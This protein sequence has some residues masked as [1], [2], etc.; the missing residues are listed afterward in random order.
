MELWKTGKWIWAEGYDSPNTYI[1]A[2]VTIPVRE[3]QKIVMAISADT[4]YAFEAGGQL[5]FGQYADY[6]FDKVYDLL[7]LTASL[8]PGDNPVTIRVWHQGDDSSTARGEAAGLIFEIF[9]DGVCV[10]A[11]G[12]ETPVRP[13]NGYA[14]GPGV[15][16]V[17][18]QLG[19]S[20]RFDARIDE[21]AFGLCI[22]AD[23]PLPV[24][25]RPIRKL[26]L[27]D[28]EPAVMTVSGTFTE[29]PDA[30]KLSLGQ[31]MQFAALRFGRHDLTRRLPSEDGI[32]LDAGEDDG[33]FFLIDTGRE[34]AG[35][36]SLD[37]DVEEEAEILIGWGEHLDDLR[38]RTII[39]GRNFAASYHARAGRNRFVHPLR[40][41]GMRYLEVH[42]KAKS[43]RIYY[44]GIKT[45]DY[46]LAHETEFTCADSLHNAI[47]AVSKRTLR[48]CM[49]EHY[50]DCPW[51]EQAL[52]TMDSRNQM[53][54]G[55]YAFRETEF[56]KASLRLMAQSI[57]EDNMLELC[58]PARVSITI[59]A[60]SAIFL[61]QV[62]EYLLFSG[63]RDF[64]GEIVPV[65][66]RIADEFI[67]R[68]DAENGLI[69][70]FTEQKYW[71]FYEW[72]S[73]LDGSIA[74]SVREEDVTFDAPLCAFVS[75]GLRALSMI[76][77]NL[78]DR[79]AAEYYFEEHR[80]LNEAVDL[81][82]WDEERGVYA[83]YIKRS[84]GEKYHY[85]ELTNALIAYADAAKG[86]RL[87]SVLVNLARKGLLPVTL[88][89]SIFK[90]EA[91][92]KQ[93]DRYARTVF[94][95]IA[96]LWGHMLHENA[97][98]FWETIDGARDFGNAGSLCH[99]WS[100]I[101]IVLYHRY[102]MTM[103]GSQTGLYECRTR[104]RE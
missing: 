81:W 12:E 38:V 58:S 102:A 34:N 10:A 80:T 71:N 6:P 3:G 104:E 52:Y 1:D 56:P 29:S 84:T 9:A 70:C 7:D 17:S 92:M 64:V 77:G 87:N 47:Y 31:R 59:P 5:F 95:D 74:G 46:P 18:G 62:Y 50:E 57:R 100:A 21:A 82:F 88:S 67:R 83:T 101:P 103:D 75:F 99:G 51:R 53:L 14:M 39:G 66:R 60:F 20:F 40:R 41:L 19:Y 8:T 93:K 65:L 55:Y 86:E 11:S 54:C 63:D 89:H 49:H 23:K 43:A 91:L 72:Q 26:I 13:V 2:A 73:G 68:R 96:S 4:N 37:L 24:R 35:L 61:T 30:E 44:A 76:L 27:G 97:T 33:V 32:A 28:D 48:M 25:E 78:G 69:P 42:V 85:A 90:Y 79:K 36:L 22:L 98:T 15:E 94:S 16:H 45:T